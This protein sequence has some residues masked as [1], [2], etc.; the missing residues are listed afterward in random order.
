MLIKCNSSHTRK[1]EAVKIEFSFPYRDPS[2]FLNPVKERSCRG[3]GR[4]AK[5]S[6]YPSESSRMAPKRLQQ[7]NCHS[8]ECSSV[9]AF[10]FDFV[11]PFNFLSVLFALAKLVVLIFAVSVLAK[12]KIVMHYLPNIHPNP[13]ELLQNYCSSTIGSALP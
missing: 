1:P 3:L 13:R 7:H 8:S 5:S 6:Q 10:N 12:I 9:N 2:G 11:A 4:V